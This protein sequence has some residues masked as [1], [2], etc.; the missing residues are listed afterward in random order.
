MRALVLRVDALQ[1]MLTQE[2]NRLGTAREAV[3]GDIE[4]H[5]GWLE[6]QIDALA[7]K[8]RQQIDDDPGMKGR[9]ELLDTIPGRRRAPLPSCWPSAPTPSISTTPAKS[10]R[11]PG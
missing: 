8:A 7:R 3:R 10:P 6:T 4:A 11:S 5:I 9:G 1:T 2:K